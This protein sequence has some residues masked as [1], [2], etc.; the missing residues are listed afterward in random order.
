MPRDPGTDYGCELGDVECKAAVVPWSESKCIFIEPDLGAVIAGIKT[1]VE[2]RLGKKIDLRADLGIKEKSQTWVKKIVD[3]AVD[4]SRRWLF[5]V[6]TF[7]I[8]CA[9]Q[10]R[11][12]IV[13]ECR[14]GE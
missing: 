1:A 14:D 8:D 12:K 13:L 9:A 7:D 6:V 10:S 11:T 3:F 5:K 2:S 4:Q